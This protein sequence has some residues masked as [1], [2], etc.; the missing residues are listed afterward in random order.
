MRKRNLFFI[1]LLLTMIFG[2]T[3]VYSALSSVLRINGSGEVAAA[4]WDIYLDN[5]S[6]YGGSTTNNVPVIT[7]KTSAKFETILNI[8]GDFYQ[9]TIDVVN[10]GDI[11]AMIESIEKLP[12]LTS[13]QAKYVNYIIEY[14]NGES[15]STKQLV[16]AGSFVRLKVKVEYKRDITNLPNSSIILDLSFKVNYIQ[17]DGTQSSVVDNGVRRLTKIVSGDLNTLGSEVMVAD[18]PFYVLSNDGIN[19]TL[20]AK[21]NLNVGNIGTEPNASG[22]DI[23][24]TSIVNP[25]GIQ[26]SNTLGSFWNS[27]GEGIDFP[28][29]GVVSFADRDYWTGT[30]SSYPSYV[31]NS[32]SHIY[33]YLENYKNYLAYNGVS[34]EEVRLLNHDE[35]TMLGLPSSMVG[36]V[37]SSVPKWV[38]STSYW[39]GFV[40]STNCVNIMYSD[41]YVGEFGYSH[42]E[43]VADGAGVRPVV[44]IALSDFSNK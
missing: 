10:A 40:R 28:W 19:V 27:K 3:V 33:P 41:G 21:Y 23:I 29:I 26:D 42:P 44:K 34:V 9:F 22:D 15:I 32:N 16:S 43:V 36:Y 18:E 31:Y 6:V 14:E 13:E 30:I 8:P 35:Y 39:M 24:L 17:T 38:Y 2:L 12:Q 1:V 25:T 20:L 37:S 7:G 5:V 4:D 11:D